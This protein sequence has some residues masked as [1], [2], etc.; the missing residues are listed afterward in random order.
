MQKL[1]LTVEQT[2]TVTGRGVI[3]APEVPLDQ[4][5]ET[6]PSIATLKRPNGTTVSTKVTFHIPHLQVRSVELALEILKEPHYTCFLR[7]IDEAS[8]PIGTEVWLG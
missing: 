8:V 4:A 7:D 5:L 6:L 2:F 3:V 1:L